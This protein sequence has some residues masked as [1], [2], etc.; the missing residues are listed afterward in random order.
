MSWMD[1]LKLRGIKGDGTEVETNPAELVDYLTYRS[2]AWQSKKAREDE[3]LGSE[4]WD[5][6]EHLEQ[7]MHTEPKTASGRDKFRLYNP[8]PS[9]RKLWIQ[10]WN[11][12]FG[13][14]L[15]AVYPTGDE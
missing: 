5:D 7:I 2:W 13:E 9:Q 8:S 6:D 12:E 15:G 4:G 1:V 11:K 14:R 10:T 3:G